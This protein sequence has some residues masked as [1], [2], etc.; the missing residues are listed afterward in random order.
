MIAVNWTQP[1]SLISVGLYTH[2]VQGVVPAVVDPPS[3]DG[4]IVFRVQASEEAIFR[5]VATEEAHFKPR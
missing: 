3:L 4:E 2:L 5:V 1:E